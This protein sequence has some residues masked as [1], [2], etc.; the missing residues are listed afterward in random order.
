M[1][2]F[3]LYTY[4]PLKVIP[5]SQR[6]EFRSD[7]IYLISTFAAILL[8][9]SSPPTLHLHVYR[10]LINI[11]STVGGSIKFKFKSVGRTRA[12]RA[13]LCAPWDLRKACRFECQG[14]SVSVASARCEEPKY[15]NLTKRFQK[16]KRGGCRNSKFIGPRKSIRRFHL[17]NIIRHFIGRH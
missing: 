2:L 14:Y 12:G 3:F 9:F 6:L 10:S 8:L 16:V 13:D 7:V 11:P 1:S 15:D 4:I 17:K 5:Y